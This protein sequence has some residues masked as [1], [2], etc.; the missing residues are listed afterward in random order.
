MPDMHPAQQND[1]DHDAV[2]SGTF[3]R[4]LA[5]SIRQFREQSGLSLSELSRRAGVAKGTLSRLEVGQGNPTIMTLAALARE[6]NVTPSD[7]FTPEDEDSVAPPPL[8]GPVLDMRFLS[9]IRSDSIWEIYET[10]IPARSEPLYSETHGGI[11]HLFLLAGE[12]RVG[13]VDAPVLLRPGG[14]TSF[15][16]SEPHLYWSPHGPSRALLMMDY[17]L[18]GDGD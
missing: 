13:P 11:E 15:A 5:A 9:R 8:A 4:Q 2:D 6:L 3:S 1:R 12:A 16:G 17:P 14:H 10:V 7:F 18:D